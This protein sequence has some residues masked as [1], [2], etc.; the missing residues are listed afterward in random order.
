MLRLRLGDCGAEWGVVAS[1][2]G[3]NT[4]MGAALF[5]GLAGGPVEDKGHRPRYDA[6]K[7]L[8]EP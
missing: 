5:I 6:E 7:R 3:T 2:M 4:V 8:D 1:S